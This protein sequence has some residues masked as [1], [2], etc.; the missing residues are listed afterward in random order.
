MSLPA[1]CK[2]AAGSWAGGQASRELGMQRRTHSNFWQKG[3][4]R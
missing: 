1:V 3:A 2:A 4:V